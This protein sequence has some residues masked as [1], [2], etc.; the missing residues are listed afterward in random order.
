MSIEVKAL[1]LLHSFSCSP[2]LTLH[3]R[4][5]QAVAAAVAA[6]LSSLLSVLV[7]VFELVRSFK[8]SKE[9]QLEA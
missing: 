5:W 1:L 3:L 8:K 7:R 2:R 9:L 6:G 4:S